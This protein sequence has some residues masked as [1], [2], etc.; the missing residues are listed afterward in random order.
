MKN[1][2]ERTADSQAYT[3]GVKRATGFV[4]AF[5]YM[6]ENPQRAL[7]PTD[8]RARQVCALLDSSLHSAALRSVQNDKLI[9]SF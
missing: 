2:K 4:S 6:K 5:K 8:M 3:Q 1:L 9:L 7:N